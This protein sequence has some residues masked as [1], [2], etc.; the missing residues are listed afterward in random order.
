ME[1]F[2]KLIKRLKFDYQTLIIILGTSI[3]TY[4]VL[5]KIE[6]R[7][8]ILF[9]IIIASVFFYYNIDNIQD[10]LDEFK[11]K[12]KEL[13]KRHSNIKDT[14]DVK[15]DKKIQNFKVK[16]PKFVK[17]IPQFNKLNNY[18]KKLE[19]F[20]KVNYKEII[21]SYG[22]TSKKNINLKL[23]HNIK[24][25]IKDY[26]NQVEII[27]INEYYLDKSLQK[28]IAI[29]KDI[30]NLIH[31]I[32][33]KTNHIYDSKVNEFIEELLEIFGE[34]EHQLKIRIN[35]MFKENPNCL[36]GCINLEPDIPDHYDPQE[37]LNNITITNLIKDN[38]I[39]LK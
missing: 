18:L 22:E 11:N 34:I 38:S 37:S 29:K 10:I 7:K 2:L 3:F 27:L 26:I 20:I 5:E 4:F 13:L 28:L 35:K 24:L 21:F 12:K 30:I 8:L 33:F 19:D 16:N 39:N 1:K 17:K 25:K 6:F 15:I 36:S 32:Y 31:S 14:K 23:F 9:F